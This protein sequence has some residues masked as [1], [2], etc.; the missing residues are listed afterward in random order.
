MTNAP[1]STPIDGNGGFSS[2]TAR[3]VAI[4]EMVSYGLTNAQIGH[5]LHMSKY[6]V[7]QHLKEMFRRTGSVNRT[8]LVARAHRLGFPR[9]QD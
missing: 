1:V 9:P 5:E 7:A 2:L 3:Q 6:T 8:D 4:L